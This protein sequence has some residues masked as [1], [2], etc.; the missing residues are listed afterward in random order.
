MTKIEGLQDM[1]R[2]MVQMGQ[3]DTKEIK[4]ILKGEGDAMIR[5]ATVLAAKKSGGLSRSIGYV[6]KNDSRF[7]TTLLIGPDYKKGGQHSHII[8]FG[9]RERFRG[10]KAGV[11]LVRTA[12]RLG[13]DD[14]TIR[15]AIAGTG[16]KST[17]IG[18]RLPFMAPAFERHKYAAEKAIK[19][20]IPILTFKQ[21]KKIKLI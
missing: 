4:K 14:D 13:I 11:K 2:K 16:L 6:N 1:V 18:P 12:V 15:T 5:T 8:E 7:P 19:V 9:T 10:S 3:I 20:K 17:G 21:A